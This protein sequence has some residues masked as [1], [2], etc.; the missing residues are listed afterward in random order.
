MAAGTIDQDA[1]YVRERQ[2]EK[3]S[4]PIDKFTKPEDWAEL[5]DHAAIALARAHAFQ[6]G[7]AAKI[8]NWVGPDQELLVERLQTYAETYARQTELD[9]AAYKRSLTA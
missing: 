4:L 6:P 1:Y 3:G 9:C 7:A 5:V 8:L 2:R